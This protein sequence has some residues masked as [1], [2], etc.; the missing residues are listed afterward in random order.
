MPSPNGDLASVKGIFR[1]VSTRD[2]EARHRHGEPYVGVR[3][4]GTDPR[5]LRQFEIQFLDGI[6]MLAVESDLETTVE[7]KS[8]HPRQP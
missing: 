5:G 6:W 4:V 8:L 2:G 3:E 7:P 1:A